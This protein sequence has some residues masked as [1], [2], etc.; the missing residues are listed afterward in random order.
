LA[1]IE[2]LFVEGLSEP[3]SLNAKEKHCTGPNLKGISLYFPND[4]KIKVLL[5]TN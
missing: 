1:F 4:L 5:N 3:I 2:P